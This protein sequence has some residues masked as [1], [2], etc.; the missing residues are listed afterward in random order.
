MRLQTQSA[1]NPI[2]RGTWDCVA[3]TVRK[4]GVRAL[5]KGE[6]LSCRPYQHVITLYS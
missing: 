6:V 3:Q 1:T 2:Y 5:Y 4:E